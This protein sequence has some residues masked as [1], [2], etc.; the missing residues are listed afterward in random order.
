[1]KIYLQPK[2]ITLVGKA[3]QI[4]YMLRNYMR[5]HELVQDWINATAPKK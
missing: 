2:G 4:K 1:M 5:Q 3:W